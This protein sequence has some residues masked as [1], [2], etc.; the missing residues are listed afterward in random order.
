MSDPDTSSGVS[1]DPDGPGLA[2]RLRRETAQAHE[3]IEHLP[4]MQRL[5][6]HSVTLDDYR[7]YL[8]TLAEIYAPLE[9]ALYAG[10]SDALRAR[11][12][13]RPKLSALLRDLAEL[14]AS[15]NADAAH[16]PSSGRAPGGSGRR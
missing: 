15:S 6:S 13:V 1:A 2:L 8:H 4:M 12:G 16:R 3:A 9:A 11:L 5:T 14:D 10:L 7:H